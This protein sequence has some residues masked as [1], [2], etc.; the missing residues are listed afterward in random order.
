MNDGTKAHLAAVSGLPASAS[1]VAGQSRNGE[2]TALR[3]LEDSREIIR[4][5]MET[6][7]RESAPPAEASQGSTRS[8]AQRLLEQVQRL[9]L[10]GL[11][12]AIRKLRR[13]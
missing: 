7:V 8:L 3:R 9:P 6:Q 12:L 10:V 13:G 2:A 5:A 1:G 4:A 11:M